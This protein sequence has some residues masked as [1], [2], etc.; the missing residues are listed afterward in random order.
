VRL[1]TQLFAGERPDPD[2][3]DPVE[4]DDRFWK[5][6]GGLWTS[7]YTPGGEHL[8]SWVEWTVGEDFKV[9]D[10]FW[11]LEPLDSR[12]GV[13]RDQADLRELADEYAVH[14]HRL[15]DLPIFARSILDYERLAADF[16]ALWIP[17]PWGHRFG[18]DPGLGIWFSTMDSEC[19]LWFRWRFERA[20]LRLEAVAR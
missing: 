11:L 14:D 4:N 8:S 3:L 16:D 9:A 2:R 13:V 5:P 6:R 17:A 10:E 15:A 18:D 7:T 20:P 19:V 12:V 1:P